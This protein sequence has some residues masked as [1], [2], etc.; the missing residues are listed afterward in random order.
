MADVKLA[1]APPSG[2]V[3][4]A[5]RL[6]RLTTSPAVTPL[7]GLMV[8][9]AAYV[10]HYLRARAAVAPASSYS[11]WL[12]GGPRHLWAT[13]VFGQSYFGA[14]PYL[15]L[16]LVAAG[17]AGAVVAKPTR[18]AVF[19]STAIAVPFAAFLVF[20]NDARFG[21]ELVGYWGAVVIPLVYSTMPA[22]ILA[23]R[24]RLTSDAR[25]SS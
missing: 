22:G 10:A 8:F 6:R 5:G 19:L 13:L 24:R 2:Q 12:Q 20:G 3:G 4:W 1:A 25:P 15:P 9:G 23:A 17:V 21:N 7:A 18:L 14:A 11:F 16:A